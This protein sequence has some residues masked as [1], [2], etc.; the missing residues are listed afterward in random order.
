MALIPL[1]N[2]ALGL[3][4]TFIKGKTPK[5]VKQAQQLTAQEIQARRKLAEAVDRYDP[6]TEVN[7]GADLAAKTTARAL[8]LAERGNRAAYSSVGAPA[9]SSVNFLRGMQRSVD[10]LTTPLGQ[11]VALARANAPAKKLEMQLRASSITSPGSIANQVLGTGYEAPSPVGSLQMLADG[12]DGLMS[13]NRPD[14]LGVDSGA[15]GRAA[16]QNSK[17]PVPWSPSKT[18]RMPRTLTK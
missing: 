1:V 9:A 5:A 11:Q 14:A 10:D 7:A 6:L 13:K 18:W 16:Y 12:I 15:S 3:A 4:G 8:Q 2:T 17:A